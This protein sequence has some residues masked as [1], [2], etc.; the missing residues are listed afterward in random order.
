MPK[1]VSVSLFV[2]LASLS[3]CGSSSTPSSI[4]RSESAAASSAITLVR[5]ATIGA[6]YAAPGPRECSTHTVPQSGSLTADDARAY[7]ICG[8]EGVSG[9]DTLTLLSNV[10][11]ETIAERPYNADSDAFDSIASDKPVYDINGHSIVWTCVT[12]GG[13][14][15]Q[16]QLCTRQDTPSDTG[17]CYQTTLAEWR[18]A[19]SDPAHSVINTDTR[20]RV[21]PPTL[22]EAE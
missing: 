1:T 14:L 13:V 4:S 15:T 8:V 7:V 16:N 6:K 20:L 5:D 12:P 19:W 18:C 11:V 17:R 22:E 3:A 21:A 10:V 2:A 9:S